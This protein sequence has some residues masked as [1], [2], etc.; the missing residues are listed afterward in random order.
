[1]KKTIFVLIAVII[2]ASIVGSGCFPSGSGCGFKRGDSSY[3][4]KSESYESLD[5]SLMNSYEESKRYSE[6]PNESKNPSENMSESNGYSESVVDGVSESERYSESIR[7]S[8][9]KSE[10]VSES[11]R[12]SESKNNSQ[13]ESEAESESENESIS[14]SESER[15]SVSESESISESEEDLEPS[16][17]KWFKFTLLSDGSGYSVAKC[18]D[19]NEETYPTEIV[20]P[21]TYNN[22]P[23]VYIDFFAFDGCNSLISI[24]ISNSV[25]VIL[26]GA[27]RGCGN[28]TSVSIP[29]A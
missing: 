7:E 14:E 2:T 24:I 21:K 26:H 15:E 19:Y 29:I 16:D 28:L 6:S 4:S 9:R 3:S 5:K 23:V 8:E 20:I 1:M 12:S 27:F 25:K 18:D 11:E 10:S 22:K 17:T 13:N